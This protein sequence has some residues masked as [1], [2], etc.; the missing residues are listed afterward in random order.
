[1]G[2]AHPT[3]DA[4]AA[5][6]PNDGCF[7]E[8]CG[9][10]KYPIPPDYE[11]IMK[12][13]GFGEKSP[14]Q[15][16]DDEEQKDSDVHED[17]ETDDRDYFD[18]IVIGMQEA[19]FEVPI[20]YA[21]T[22][23]V[24]LNKTILNKNLMKAIEKG[25]G[26]VD[27]MVKSRDYTK[28]SEFT[29]PEWL[30]AR[31]TKILVE[32]IHSRCPSYE[33]V[34]CFQRGEMRLHILA[35]KS[36]EVQTLSIKAQNTGIGV[37]G[38]MNAA[39]KGGIVAELLVEKSTRISFCTA[40]LQAHEGQERYEE[41]CRM[42]SAILEGTAAPGPISVDMANR[43]HMTFFLGDLN[44]RTE[45]PDSSE[46]SKDDHIE[47][48]MN[49]VEEENWHDLNLADE[50]FKALRDKDCLVGF[51]TLPCIFPPTFKVERTADLQYKDQRRPSYTDRILWKAL[52]KLEGSIRPVTYEPVIEFPTSDHKPVRGAFEI[53]LNDVIKPRDP[54]DRSHMSSSMRD[55]FHRSTHL[56]GGATDTKLHLFIS[57]I[58]CNIRLLAKPPD[59]C[60]LFVTYPYSLVQV[61]KGIW[62][63]FR[64]NLVNKLSGE[65]L[66]DDDRKTATGFPRTRKLKRT[67]RPKWKDEE[68]LI[69]QTHDK[70]GRPLNLTGAL[71]FLVVVDKQPIEH[72]IIGIFPLN[73]AHLSKSSKPVSPAHDLLEDFASPWNKVARVIRAG[74]PG[75]RRRASI[76]LQPRNLE[77]DRLLDLKQPITK[78]G[79]QT[80]WISLT[81]DSKW[82]S[83]NEMAVEM[84]RR[85]FGRENDHRQLRNLI[86]AGDTN[87]S[88]QSVASM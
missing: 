8:V 81:I 39:N 62:N 58:E 83:D 32:M 65:T 15:K 41:R 33:I 70:E 17:N 68:H 73:L 20:D 64:G 80:G 23:S 49:L 43:S 3:Q 87:H 42:I 63:Q 67:Y 77:D 27:S 12:E 35:R 16:K 26:L 66:G 21:V 18:L 22:K 59:P 61:Q 25:S 14:Y 47:R 7:S 78:N 76:R 9:N 13:I 57:N 31:D 6:L 74:A 69:I 86:M 53:L 75:P 60:V 19:T 2:N 24:L 30:D 10:P 48:V 38:I 45:L 52:H 50:L 1:M 29:L 84:A 34:A 54:I 71:L 85:S 36:L 51:K 44:F 5:L 55:M 79:R 46:W 28:A 82:L 11:S 40:H 4:I 88:G 72:K 37:N 56:M